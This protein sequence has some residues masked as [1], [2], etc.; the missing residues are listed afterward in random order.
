MLQ[1]EDNT[2][3][4]HLLIIVKCPLKLNSMCVK[5]KHSRC[6]KTNHSIMVRPSS[7]CNVRSDVTFGSSLLGSLFFLWLLCAFSFTLACLWPPFHD[8]KWFLIIMLTMN[9]CQQKLPYFTWS[10]SIWRKQSTSQ[11]QK[12]YHLIFQFLEIQ[13]NVERFVFSNGCQRR[14]GRGHLLNNRKSGD[15]KRPGGCAGNVD[16]SYDGGGEGAWL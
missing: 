2:L 12:K 10:R 6:H 16:F 1:C 4:W 11:Q 13:A 3:N 15:S 9:N 14:A 5:Q 8:R 7:G